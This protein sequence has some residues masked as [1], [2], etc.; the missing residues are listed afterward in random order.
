[1]NCQQAQSS[2]SLYLYGELDFAAEENLET[3]LAECAACQLS[4]AREKQWHTFTNGQVQEP[5]F[6]LLAE[7]RQQLRPAIARENVPPAANVRSWWRWGNPFEI[8][9]TRW[10]SQIALASLLV[11]LGFASARLLDHGSWRPFTVNQMGLLNPANAF[12]RDVQADDKGVV[13]IVLEQESAITGQID[14]PNVRSLLLSASRQSDVGVR[15]Y[16]LQILNRQ[17]GDLR[18]DDPRNDDLRQVFFDSVRNDPNPAVRLEAVEGLRRFSADPGA[19]EVLK[20]VL[21]HDDDP[22]VRSQAINVLA[23]PDHDAKITPAMTQTI[24]D[25]LRSSPGDEYV[26]A[27]CSQVLEEAKLP[28]VY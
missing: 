13:R 11:A 22:G 16:S 7:C 26:R 21:E 6:D 28:V 25:V 2:L 15:F 5:P 12:V 8:S 1:V 17:A 20:F 24:A 9:A 10:S 3:H 23:P 19:L 4:L 14:D 27:R 18:N